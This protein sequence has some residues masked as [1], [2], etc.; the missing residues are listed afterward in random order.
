MWRTAVAETLPHELLEIIATRLSAAMLLRA[1]QVCQTWR[2]AFMSDEEK[3]WEPLARKRFPRLA[4]LLALRTSPPA[5]PTFKLLYRRL[6]T[7]G[8][9]DPIDVVPPQVFRLPEYLLSYEIR[10]DDKLKMHGSAPMDQS[11]SAQ[12]RLFTELP[13][14]YLGQGS[15][16]EWDGRLNLAVYATRQSDMRMVKLYETNQTMRDGMHTLFYIE[17]LPGA[18]FVDLHRGVWND[19][20]TSD[21]EQIMIAPSKHLAGAPL[22][23]TAEDDDN[24]GFFGCI[25]LCISCATGCYIRGC[26]GS[27]DEFMYAC[28][29]NNE[30]DVPS[31][32]LEIYLAYMAPWN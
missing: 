31:D 14:W 25:D 22:F 3:L 20:P 29:E 7:A 15:D 11:G 9:A 10:L 16:I 12:A 21:G 24:D 18:P 23:F 8:R 17:I 27:D 1:V 2:A 19:S 28:L 32:Q 13:Q 30:G 4:S 26:V 5:Q 6:L